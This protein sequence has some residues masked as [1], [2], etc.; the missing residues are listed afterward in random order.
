M[1]K[2]SKPTTEGDCVKGLEKHLSII[3]FIIHSSLLVCP[4]T[5][6]QTC[7]P[8]R[9]LFR[10]HTFW[11]QSTLVRFVT[12]NYAKSL[13][14]LTPV[15]SIV[16]MQYSCLSLPKKKEYDFDQQWRWIIPLLSPKHPAVMSEH[17]WQLSSQQRHCNCRFLSNSLL[18]P[19]GWFSQRPCKSYQAGVDVKRLNCVLS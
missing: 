17:D 3:I 2:D 7:Q 1:Q 5:F 6:K 14:C 11:H 13:W 4:V 18:T 15:M 19:A 16:H 9:I 10:R 8:V 12:Q